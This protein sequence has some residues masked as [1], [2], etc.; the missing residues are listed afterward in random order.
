MSKLNQ[1][2]GEATL[3]WA[4]GALAVEKRVYTRSTWFEQICRAWFQ[5]WLQRRNR[6]EA[7]PEPT[8]PAAAAFIMVSVR[9]HC[10]LKMGSAQKA[11]RRPYSG[12]RRH[13]EHGFPAK[14]SKGLYQPLWGPCKARVKP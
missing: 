1:K 2:R 9:F 4:D 6:V 8:C 11:L 3:N 7:K 12:L 5:R 10:V 14:T 13:P